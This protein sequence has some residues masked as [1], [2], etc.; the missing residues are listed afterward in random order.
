MEGKADVAEYGI[1]ASLGNPVHGFTE[2]DQSCNR[3][4]RDPV[5]HGYDDGFPGVP[6]DDSF[7]TDFFSS[8]TKLPPM[9]RIPG[10]G[11]WNQAK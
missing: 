3:P 8:H 6:V 1:G 2:I 9:Q 4:V 5:I 10:M 11:P 7:Q